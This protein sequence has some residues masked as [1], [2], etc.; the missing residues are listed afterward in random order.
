[1]TIFKK[2]EDEIVGDNIDDFFHPDVIRENNSDLTFHD[3]GSPSQKYLKRIWTNYINLKWE[4]K[5]LHNV[6]I[7]FT[8]DK[9]PDH[10][11]QGGI[12][13]LEY[14]NYHYEHFRIKSISVVDYLLLFINHCL[15][16]GIPLKKCNIYSITENTNI[17][18]SDLVQS[19]KD[20]DQEISHL[21]TDRNKIIH[22][23][24]F[25]PQSMVPLNDLIL[26]YEENVIDEDDIE[27]GEL[28]REEINKA[29]THFRNEINMIN[30]HV[31]IVLNN[32]IPHIKKQVEIIKLTE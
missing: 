16:I 9:I 1:M 27:K 12:H 4:L 15:Q 22:E 20:F 7:F 13:N 3:F 17:K 30:A 31:E 8:I 21:K 11:N 29:I 23:G 18:N 2:F 6:E 19:L 10:Y 26:E 5:R 14:Y 32:L 24:T 25:E 28:K